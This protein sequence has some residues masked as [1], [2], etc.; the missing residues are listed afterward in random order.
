MAGGRQHPQR[1]SRGGW[2]GFGGVS[3]GGRILLPCAVQGACDEESGCKRLHPAGLW[4]CGPHLMAEERMRRG[5]PAAISER[6]QSFLMA[7]TG[8]GLEEGKKAFWKCGHSRAARCLSRGRGRHYGVAA[9]GEETTPAPSHGLW[10]NWDPQAAMSA[11]IGVYIHGHVPFSERV[12]LGARGGWQPPG[13]LGLAPPQ[14]RGSAQPSKESVAAEHA[15]NILEIIKKVV[16]E[17]PSSW[18]PACR[19]TTAPV[20][21]CARQPSSAARWGHGHPP[22]AP[23]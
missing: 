20:G 6:V 7:R 17:V 21:R 9:G 18:L 8:G 1:G 3:Q 11:S 10:C 23:H 5:L 22:S 12:V 13:R 15:P 2:L 16:I 4:G 19:L 14:S